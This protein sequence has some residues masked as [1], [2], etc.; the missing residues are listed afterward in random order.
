MKW[1]QR[2]RTEKVHIPAEKISASR[3]LYENA[4]IQRTEI[5]ILTEDN[6]ELVL[7]LTQS[8]T[9]EMAETMAILYR[10]MTQ[11]KDKF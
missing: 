6:A 1:F 11:T 8:Q 3:V 9:R 7:E 5:R 2:M 4:E 10:T